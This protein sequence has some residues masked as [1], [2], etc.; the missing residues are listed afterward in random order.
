MAGYV[1]LGL[2]VADELE[3]EDVA[4]N[5]WVLDRVKLQDV[6]VELALQS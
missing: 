6:H 1:G 4:A 3:A 5:V 2:P